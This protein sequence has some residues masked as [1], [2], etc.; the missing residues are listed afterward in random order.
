[1]ALEASD[2]LIDI[3]WVKWRCTCGCISRPTFILSTSLLDIMG[4]LKEI[5]QDC[6]IV[7][8]TSLEIDPKYEPNAWRYHVHLHKQSH[9]RINPLGPRI[10]HTPWSHGVYTCVLLFV[11]M[12]V[13][14][15]GVWK[16]LPRMNQVLTNFFWFPHDVKQGLKVG[17]EIHPQ[18]HLQL[19]KIM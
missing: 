6:R 18:V 14:P 4:K 8:C 9:P 5:K 19:T 3:I 2:R 1:M 10:S 17:L 11:Q 16:L 12:N 15:S 7:F 13:V